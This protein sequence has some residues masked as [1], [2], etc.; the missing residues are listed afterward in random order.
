M[1]YLAGIK[2]LL[3]TLAPVLV[4]EG[5]K[6]GRKATRKVWADAC[7]KVE[8]GEAQDHLE[9]VKLVLKEWAQWLRQGPNQGP[10]TDGA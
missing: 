6:M 8:T 7:K 1:F 4:E 5:A 9:A 2:L 3:K 10:A